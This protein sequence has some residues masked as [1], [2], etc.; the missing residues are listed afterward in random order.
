MQESYDVKEAA[1]RLRQWQKDAEIQGQEVAKR[2]GISP[3]YYSDIRKG[4]QRGSITVLAKICE[5]LGHDVGDLLVG[6]PKP[7]PQFTKTGLRKALR[8]LMGKQT[9]DAV[10]CLQL[11]FQAP[12]AL[13]RALRAY[14][15]DAIEG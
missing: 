9:D 1:R 7:K 4:K 5:V 10:E 15:I 3:P 6:G 11:W 13:K 8:P 14:G 2:V 12:A